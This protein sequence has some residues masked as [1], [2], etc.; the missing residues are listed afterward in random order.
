ME[1]AFSEA[2]WADSLAKLPTAD[3]ASLGAAARERRPAP[4]HVVYGGAHLFSTQTIDKLEQI[5]RSGF[6]TYLPDGDALAAVFGVAPSH[7]EEIHRRVEAQL[8]REPVADCR[9]DF[10]DGYGPR[11]DDE[12]D[13]HAS[14]AG[15]AVAMLVAAGRL[16]D[17][18]IGVRCK[19]L[20]GGNGLRAVRT[21][22]R[23][24]DAAKVPV[25]V[26]VPKVETVDEAAAASA[27]V[28][29]LERAYG[30]PEQGCVLELMAETPAFFSEG[31]P[32][33]HAIAAAASGG[34]RPV[35]VHLGSYDLTAGAGVP[36]L[37]Q[38]PD[39]PILDHARTALALAFG[40][41]DVELSDGATTTLPIAP[42][43]Q[44]KS[45]EERMQNAQVVTAAFRQHA[46][47]VAHA[48][49]FGIYESWVLHPMQ[50]I[51]HRVAQTHF[52]IEALPSARSRLARFLEGEARASR[53]GAEFDDA[54]TGRGLLQF[55][56]RAAALG[57]LDDDDPLLA[58]TRLR[59]GGV[60]TRDGG[61]LRTM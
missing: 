57:M 43:K 48:L 20:A 11:S 40:T 46:S 61:G 59:F 38:R 10:E 24:F 32:K 30:L 9:I 12:E 39:H 17:R 25:R 15:E 51:S 53:V 47:D 26:T 42:H 19:R 27:L 34:G 55:F 7:A 1:R 60:S 44:P 49:R 18:L 33:L 41:S 37:A 13:A 58:E 5:A 50:L 36:F 2:A 31:I 6:A 14:A 56:V 54:A 28:A 52:F 22:H 45:N 8:R 29:A 23:F 16:G 3:A 35:A 4:S 21:L